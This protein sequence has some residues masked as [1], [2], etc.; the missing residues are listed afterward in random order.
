MND[1]YLPIA[2]IYLILCL[3]NLYGN[4]YSIPSIEYLSKPLLM[5]VLGGYFYLHTQSDKSGFSR[6]ILIGLFFSWGGDTLLML[7]KP[8]ATPTNAHLYFM[9]GLVSFLLAHIFY[10]LA[11][12][13]YP[14][15]RR[16]WVTRNWT[17]VTPFV[18]FWIGFNIFFWNNLGDMRLPVMVYSAVI[19][20]MA[21]TALNMTDQ[22]DRK[23]ATLIAL[24]AFIFMAS[25]TIIAIDRFKHHLAPP[26][27]HFYIML[28]YLTAQWLIV[29]GSIRAANTTLTYTPS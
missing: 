5:I 16:G 12:V 24:G 17:V 1:K 8:L 28:L 23:A 20:F 6:S 22:T 7:E 19:T 2:L 9:G 11:F 4:I 18:L 27:P 3:L 25:D 10:S 15:A 14:S 29:R 26:N 13:Q 21:A